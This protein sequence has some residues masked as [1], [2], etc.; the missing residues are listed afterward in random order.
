M[1][2][3][4]PECPRLNVTNG[5]LLGNMNNDGSRKQVICNPDYIEVSGAIITTC[6][7]GNWI[8]KP[9]CIVKPCLTNPCMNMGECVINGT[10]HFCSCRPW[11]KGSN[12]ETF[13]NP[14]H[15]GCYDDSPVRVL[16]YMQKT[17]ATNDPNEC[18]K[19]CGEHNYS[20]AGVEV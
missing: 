12:C 7:N 18:A 8:P 17:S 9:K 15:C 19:H 16:P 11:W 6:I 13:S 2:C 14:V 4:K 10:G 1:Q 5:R 20:F 3:I